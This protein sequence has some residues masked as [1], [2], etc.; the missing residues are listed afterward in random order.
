MRQPGCLEQYIL[1]KAAISS[2][3]AGLTMFSCV[4]LSP[5]VNVSGVLKTFETVASQN[6]LNVFVN[7]KV[8]RYD[9]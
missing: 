2:Q 8:N 7:A 9:T 6:N 4:L 5:S 3:Q 1:I